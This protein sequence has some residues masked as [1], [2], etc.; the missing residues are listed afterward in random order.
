MTNAFNMPAPASAGPRAPRAKKKEDDDNR[1]EASGLRIR[2]VE[3][4]FETSCSFEPK[5][6]NPKL[7]RYSQMPE[8]EE[9]VFEGKD[10][11]ERGID[12]VTGMLRTAYA[13][14]ESEGSEGGEGTEPP[15]G[16]TPPTDNY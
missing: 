10:G 7:D 8:D 15:A 16:D 3:N 4:G 2:F 1:G 9:M 14:E 6:I 13:A 12:Y 11:L 5:K